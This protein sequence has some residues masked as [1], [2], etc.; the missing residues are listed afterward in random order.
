MPVIDV[1]GFENCQYHHINLLNL[2]E[3]EIGDDTKIGTFVEIGRNVKI[4]KRC[5]I[6]SFVFIPEGV[7]IGDDVFIGPGA[8]FCNVKHPMTG[9]KYQK[10]VVKDKTVIGARAVILPGITIGEGAMV[11]AGA[12]VT[13]NVEDGKTVFGNP[14]KEM[15]GLFYERV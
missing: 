12:V 6:Q 13:K 10:T 4:G 14:A 11:G 1:S 8:V 7:T 3:C 5:K 2:Y 9:E 15:A